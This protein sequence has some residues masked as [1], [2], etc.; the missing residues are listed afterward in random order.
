MLLGKNATPERKD[1]YEPKKVLYW[2]ETVV[3]S[4]QKNPTRI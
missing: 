4:S 2:A 1:R 3:K